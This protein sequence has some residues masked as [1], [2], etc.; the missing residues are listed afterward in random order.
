[1]MKLLETVMGI[2]MDMN[3]KWGINGD[4]NQEG[5]VGRSGFWGR[6]GET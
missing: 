2:R 5:K 3:S 1:M 6:R 4:I